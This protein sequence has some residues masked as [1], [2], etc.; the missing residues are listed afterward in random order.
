M[1][2]ARIAIT[3]LEAELLDLAVTAHSLGKIA[4]QSASIHP[5]TTYVNLT[6]VNRLRCLLYIPPFC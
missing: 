6:F 5:D 3:E 2:P 4:G 1:I